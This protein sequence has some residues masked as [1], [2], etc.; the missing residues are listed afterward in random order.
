MV[1]LLEPAMPKPLAA[2]SYLSSPDAFPS[3]IARH[4]NGLRVHNYAKSSVDKAEYILRGFVAWCNDRG[5]HEPKE[6][7][8]QILERYQSWLFTYRTAKDKPLKV[9]TQACRL[10]HIRMFFKWLAKER[11]ILFNPA[12][13]LDLPKRSK[14]IP[15]NVLTAA[16]VEKIMRQ[17]EATTIG[18]RNRAILETLYATGIRRAELA[19]MEPYDIQFQ[20]GAVLVR[21]G[22]GQKDRVVPISQR[23]CEWIQ[24]YLRKSRPFLAQSFSP[25][26]LFL[27]SRG[28]ALQAEYI[29]KIVR[30]YVQKTD[31]KVEGACHIFRHTMAT[32]ML[33]NGADTRHIQKILG[34]ANLNT[35]QIYTKVSIKKLKEVHE[36]THPGVTKP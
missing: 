26:T 1:N 18:L 23:A 12:S 14:T 25:K 22:K 5:I 24:T 29:S 6:V 13:D 16:Q 4:L 2:V 8:R 10:T 17:T 27:S 20:Q 30:D 35:T 3:L 9:A 28:N 33:E 15:R 31:I 21:L 11:L 7:T 36:A 32:L 34:H 19:N